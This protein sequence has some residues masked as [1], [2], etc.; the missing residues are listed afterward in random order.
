MQTANALEQFC[1]FCVLPKRSNFLKD[2]QLCR[3]V[4]MCK[5]MFILV[6]QIPVW[7]EK[8][9]MDKCPGVF[10]CEYLHLRL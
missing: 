10:T 8:S 1:Q 3:S 9:V 2:F 5:N 4:R 7:W 6:T